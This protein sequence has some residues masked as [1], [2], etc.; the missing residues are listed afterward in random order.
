[1]AVSNSPD[2]QYGFKE[3]KAAAGSDFSADSIRT[4]NVD[5]DN[6]LEIAR[7]RV[8]TWL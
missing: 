7:E 5:E 6:P 8:C 2:F 3:D 1:M 4:V